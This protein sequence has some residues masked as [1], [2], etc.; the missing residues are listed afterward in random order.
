MKKLTIFLLLFLISCGSSEE[1]IQ[2]RIDDVVEQV[3]SSTTTSTSST[4]TSTQPQ[5]TNGEVTNDNFNLSFQINV[6][7]RNA[8]CKIREYVQSI[9]IPV[10]Q[11][12]EEIGLG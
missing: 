9:N 1:E 12:F 8:N 2:A 3:T 10:K 4:T 6:N 5:D 11:Y 7:Q